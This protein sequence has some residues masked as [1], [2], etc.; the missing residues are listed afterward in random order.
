[1]RI[2]KYNALLLTFGILVVAKAQQPDTDGERFFAR[3]SGQVAT[4]LAYKAIREELKMTED[5]VNKVRDW[6][7]NFRSKAIQIKKDKG[8]DLAGKGVV[9]SVPSFSPEELKKMASA[10]AEIR[11]VSYEELSDI[12]K[13]AQIE[14]LKQIELQNM[15]IGAFFKDEVKMALKLTD[16]QKNTMDVIAT[17]ASKAINNAFKESRAGGEFASDKYEE[18]W[19]KTEKESYDKAIALLTEE[20][21]KKWKEMI[22]EP[23]DLEKIRL[24]LPKKKN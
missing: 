15:E 18:F 2:K 23:F 17:E 1:M 24:Q 8:V 16:E 19:R 4:L 21:K 12:L 9:G 14:R 10:N 3:A 5:E 7:K 13:K 11:K 6:T 22:G 20:Q